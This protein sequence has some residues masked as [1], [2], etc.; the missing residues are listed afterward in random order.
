MSIEQKGERKRDEKRTLLI[1]F[2]VRDLFLKKTQ[3]RDSL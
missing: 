2:G 1:D 3:I